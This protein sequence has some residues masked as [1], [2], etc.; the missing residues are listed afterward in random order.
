MK[1]L[2]ILFLIANLICCCGST[3]FVLKEI[4]HNENTSLFFNSIIL[5]LVV[6]NLIYYRKLYISYLKYEQKN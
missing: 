1:Y 6:I 3:L 2:I 5:G 4:V